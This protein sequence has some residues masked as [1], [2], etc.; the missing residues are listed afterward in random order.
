MIQRAT[1][2]RMLYHRSAIAIQVRWRYAKQKARRKKIMEPT[3]KIQRFWR[4]IRSAL[5]MAKYESNGDFLVANMKASLRKTRDKYFV[6]CVLK[7]QRVWR[8]AIG[9]I[10]V[11]RMHKKSDTDSGCFPR[12]PRLGDARQRRQAGE[13]AAARGAAG[14]P[15]GV[16]GGQ[17][18]PGTIHR[19][20]RDHQ[21]KAGD[22]VV[23]TPREEF[24][25]KAPVE[26]SGWPSGA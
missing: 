2:L 19:A 23:P 11:R 7:I 12:V 5:R 18:T 14:R 15:Q 6:K 10:W 24:V 9:R 4:A 21:S 16:Q 3:K 13:R 8:G 1:M 17:D 25:V 20:D 22:H 26:Q